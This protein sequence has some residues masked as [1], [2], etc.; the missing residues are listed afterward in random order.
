MLRK[1]KTLLVVGVAALSLAFA[2]V[3]SACVGPQCGQASAEAGTDATVG[4]I[5]FS[6]DMLT[7]TTAPV[8]DGDNLNGYSAAGGEFTIDVS[9]TALGKDKRILW[10][11]IKGKAYAAVKIDD[12]TLT[13]HALVFSTGDKDND[14]GGLSATYV[15]GIAVLD[16]DTWAYATGNFGCLQEAEVAISGNLAVVAGGSASVTGPNGSYA[17]TAGKGITS[18][19]FAGSDY[20]SEKYNFWIIFPI[21]PEAY[22]E[23]D[24]KVIGIQDLFVKA[25]VS[26][27][28]Q[29]TFNLGIVSGGNV[30]ASGD[31]HLTGDVTASGVVVQAAQAV[32]GGAAVYGNSMASYSNA[33]G[34]VIE[35]CLPV[36][37]GNGLAVVTGYNNII[38]TGSQLIINSHQTAY[39]T[40]K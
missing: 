30:V 2:P 9:A 19:S 5:D 37:Q 26:A 14:T 1:L 18:A 27:D 20:D 21:D 12:T 33:G 23:L 6:V 17:Q 39:A 36:A 13:T 4:G 8:V 34:N 11:T 29:T 3:A 35:R 40:T 25:Y 22:A 38:N 24:G 28:G 31:V 7:P 16:I 32:G 15:M 10:W